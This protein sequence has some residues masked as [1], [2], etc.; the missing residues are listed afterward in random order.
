MDNRS[1][2]FV[3]LRNTSSVQTN[4]VGLSAVEIET[5]LQICQGLRCETLVFAENDFLT[6]QNTVSSNCFTNTTSTAYCDR[7]AFAIGQIFHL[8][9]SFDRYSDVSINWLKFND[10][11]SPNFVH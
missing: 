1:A 8:Y 5:V 4:L 3:K 9:L 7:F 10:L 6:C 2:G 11:V